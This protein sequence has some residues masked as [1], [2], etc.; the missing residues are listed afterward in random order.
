MNNPI[1]DEDESSY[2]DIENRTANVETN[3]LDTMATPTLI[4]DKWAC[5]FCTY[6]NFAVAQRCTMC[7]QAKISTINT[8]SGD[9][10]QLNTSSDFQIQQDQAQQQ[11]QQQQIPATYIDSVEK[12]PCDQCTFLNYP[13][14]I[15]CTQC[16]SYRLIGTSRVSSVQSSS[17][18]NTNERISLPPSTA[19]SRLIA[20]R[21][22]KWSCSR[23]TTDSKSIGEKENNNNNNNKHANANVLDERI[24][25]RAS[26]FFFILFC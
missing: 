15:R 5:S 14:A 18:I 16:G 11:Q 17:D 4:D 9:I 7:R 20:Q 8:A 3:T 13:R 6:F 12:W 19:D 24:K 2:D 23:C 1:D 22:R 26:F 21:L 25:N 10:Y